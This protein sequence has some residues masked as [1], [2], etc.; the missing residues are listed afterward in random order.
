MTKK[1]AN[2]F[3]DNNDTFFVIEGAEWH[4]RRIIKCTK[5][6][7]QFSYFVVFQKIDYNKDPSWVSPGPSVV[8][9]GIRRKELID[10][11]SGSNLIWGVINM[12][13]FIAEH[14]TELL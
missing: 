10:C 7:D 1:E 11:L 4:R 14:F 8:H 9:R 12:E 6:E 3:I 13:D 5:R 2:E